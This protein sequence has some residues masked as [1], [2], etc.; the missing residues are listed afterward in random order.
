MGA[1]ITTNL[2]PGHRS[3]KTGAVFLHNFCFEIPVY[4]CGFC[5]HEGTIIPFWAVG[6][7]REDSSSNGEQ[8]YLKYFF[9]LGFRTI[10]WPFA[11]LGAFFRVGLPRVILA[12]VRLKLKL[13]GVSSDQEKGIF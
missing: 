2:F 1:E 9:G 4:S 5:R 10:L 7:E 11:S 6:F 13:G 3:E 8:P 12:E